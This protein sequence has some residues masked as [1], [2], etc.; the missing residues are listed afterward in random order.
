MGLL[1]TLF[2]T[3][4]NHDD[5]GSPSGSHGETSGDGD[6]EDTDDWTTDH[7]TVRKQPIGGSGW[8]TVEGFEKMDTP[9]DAETFE[10]NCDALEVNTKY[11]LFALDGSRLRRPKDPD[12]RWKMKNQPVPDSSTSGSTDEIDKLERK[13]DKLTAAL[14]AQQDTEEQTPND[15]DKMLKAA[16]TNLAVAALNSEQF[17]AEHGDK[18]ALGAFETAGM[19]SD[20]DAAIDF[21]SFQNSPLSAVAFQALD[22]PKKMEELGEAAGGSMGAMLSGVSRG[23]ADGD[24]G[25]ETDATAQDE[26]GTTA[27]DEHTP[28]DGVSSGP[29]SLGDLGGDS[30]AT[31][32]M[33]TLDEA[34]LDD[35]QQQAASDAAAAQSEAEQAATTA[36]TSSSTRG[37]SAGPTA[38]PSTDAPT[39]ERDEPAPEPDPDTHSDDAAPSES[40]SEL[41]DAPATAAS[42][43]AQTDEETT[44]E[45]KQQCAAIAS[46]GDQCQNTA[47]DGSDYCHLDAHAPGDE[48]DEEENPSADDVAAAL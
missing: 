3:P 14:Q 48:H 21:D 33:P 29:S 18:I 45:P 42:E 40:T 17:V 34:S 7:Y 6:D 38:E 35:A 47:V 41:A 24:T 2:G 15:P 43:P 19:G 20:S 22:N 28:R 13:V 31:Q 12:T 11:M 4:G 9:I 1:D 36:T 10:F 23:M 30:E 37:M 16:Q 27:D 32:T 44:T 8:A 46:T 25:A 5:D 39:H 26:T